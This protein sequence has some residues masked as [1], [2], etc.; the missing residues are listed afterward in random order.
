MA[1]KKKIE[2][3]AQISVKNAPGDLIQKLQVIA[4][5]EGVT[6]N[7]VYLK[8]FSTYV[9]LYEQRHGRLKIKEKGSGLDVI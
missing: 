1:T 4:S 6:F 8:A 2:E 5:T 9:D 3:I 7:D